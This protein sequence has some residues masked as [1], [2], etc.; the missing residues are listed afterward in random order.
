VKVLTLDDAQMSRIADHVRAVVERAPSES[1]YRFNEQVRGTGAAL[2]PALHE[3]A[4]TAPAEAVLVTGLPQFDAVAL[5]KA[6]TLLLTDCLGKTVAYADFNGSLLTDIRPN[7]ESREQNAQ[8][9]LLGMHN[10]FPFAADRARPAYITL[11]AH[12]AAGVVPRT[13]L[14]AS[15]RIA[16]ALSVQQRDAL[17]KPS[18]TITVGHKLAW[19]NPVTYQF[20]LLTETA[21]GWRVSFHFDAITT[22]PTLSADEFAVAENARAALGR[23]AGE[24][25]SA[26]GHPLRKGEAL[27]IPN[28]HY[29]HGREPMDFAASRRLLFRAYALR[30]GVREPWESPVVRLDDV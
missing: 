18:F 19:R 4:R 26:D 22:D 15:D 3:H 27:V 14:A 24:I 17:A 25:G 5:T 1:D 23:L 20:P 8:P 29:L 13:L 10:D 9:S 30:D 21:L 28:D 16:A 6:L 11:V 12:E 7:L 2:L